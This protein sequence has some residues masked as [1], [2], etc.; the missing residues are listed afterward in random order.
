[1][2]LLRKIVI[3]T[4]ILVMP[5]SSWATVM[6]TSHCQTSDNTSHSNTTQM[7]DGESM[8]LHHQIPSPE[9]NHQSNCECDDNLNCSVSGCST[10]A[11]L[12]GIM[13]GP[14]NSDNPIYQRVQSHVEPSE[15]NLLFRPPI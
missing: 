2:K 9:S 7:D 8:H 1:M 11:L 10:T 4:M 3:F 14:Y 5:V 15:P 6:M 12:N 13:M